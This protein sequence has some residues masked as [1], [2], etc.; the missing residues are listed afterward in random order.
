MRKQAGYE[1][2]ERI[3][4][5]IKAKGEV[6]SAV[7]N[8]ADYIK[9]ETLTVELQQGSEFIWDLETEVEINGQKVVLGIR[10]EE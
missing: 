3:Y 1:V 5:Q 2:Y 10:R 7:T 8:F 9:R 6:E 4:L